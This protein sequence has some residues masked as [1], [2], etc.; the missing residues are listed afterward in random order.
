MGQ[1][2]A[3]QQQQAT[4]RTETANSEVAAFSQKAEFLGDVRNDMADLIEMAANRGYSM[5]MKEA[6][7]KACALSPQIT[8]VLAERSKRDALTGNKT[9]MES[10]RIAAYSLNGQRIGTNSGNSSMSM[11]DTI[12]AAWDNQNRI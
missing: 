9:T 1:Q 5:S 4:Q 12:A 6:Y 2:K 7:G 8:A 3:Y 11:H 10:K